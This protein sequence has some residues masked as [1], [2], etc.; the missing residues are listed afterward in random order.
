VGC[1]GGCTG[2]AIFL[3]G[4]DKNMLPL[5]ARS[6]RLYSMSLADS[7][8][9]SS[10]SSLFVST[11]AVMNRFEAIAK[12]VFR[13]CKSWCKVSVALFVVIW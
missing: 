10:S 7:E 11:K 2:W 1:V 6:D 3:A 9:L 4:S 5:L 13:G 8:L 12:V